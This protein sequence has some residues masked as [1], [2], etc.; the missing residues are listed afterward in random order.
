MNEILKTNGKNKYRALIEI[1]KLYYDVL[2]DKSKN[3]VQNYP[4]FAKYSKKGIK[5]VSVGLKNKKYAIKKFKNDYKYD[6]KIFSN[7]KFEY[8]VETEKFGIE[9]ISNTISNK[10]II[11]SILSDIK[12]KSAIIYRFR[13][14]EI[15][16]LELEKNEFGFSSISYK[17]KLIWNSIFDNEFNEIKKVIKL[18]KE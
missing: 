6:L 9:I 16:K 5:Y 11:Q 17:D 13:N 10:S 7:K 3:Q 18:I 12:G 1:E 2:V 8:L 14:N 4:Y 15:Q